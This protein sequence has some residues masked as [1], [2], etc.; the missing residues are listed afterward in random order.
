MESQAK[1]LGVDDLLKLSKEDR[2]KAIKDGTAEI[3]SES[4]DP[5][6]AKRWKEFYLSDPEKIPQK[7]SAPAP[8]AEPLKEEKK[9]Q[10][11]PPK[12][13][14][15]PKEEKPPEAP[16]P[17]PESRFKSLEEAEKAIS[18]KESLIN[19]QLESLSK[20]NQSSMAN[21]QLVKKLE[22]DLEALKKAKKEEKVIEEIEIPELPEEPEAPDPTDNEKY[23]EGVY[24][25]KFIEADA[26]YR[27]DL[28]SYRKIKKEHNVKLTDTLKKINEIRKE[29]EELKPQIEDVKK[30]KET[31][32][33]QRMREETE[34]NISSRD[35]IIEEMQKNLGFE[36]SVSWKRINDAAL[37]LN[38]EKADPEARN[39][40]DSLIKSLS[41]EDK[42]QYQ[43]L[44]KAASVVF[45]NDGRPRYKPNSRLFRAALEDEGFNFKEEFKKESPSPE[46]DL[47]KV[48]QEKT[49][50]SGIPPDKIGGDENIQ[51][52]TRDEKLERLKEIGKILDEIQHKGG[53]V[54]KEAPNIWA[55]REKLMADLG[56][57]IE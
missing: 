2:L 38:N 5:E 36:T 9:E 17:K 4:K 44:V 28:N 57:A 52:K 48:K 19:K 11:E 1:K 42:K 20:L 51:D 29:I 13:D 40:A 53:S 30:F 45:E 8:E 7:D 15:K 54:K 47:T 26:K 41:E 14:I 27:K 3:P 6:G 10:T 32:L 50:V 24:D 23:P 16:E 43:N 22:A 33:T 55:E 49:A 21:S 34:R 18:E 46:V 12:D 25:D 37:I 31:S 39:I 35:S 56:V